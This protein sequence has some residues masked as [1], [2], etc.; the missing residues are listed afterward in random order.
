MSRTSI[1]KVHRTLEEATVRMAAIAGIAAGVVDVA[2]VVVDEAEVAVGATAVVAADVT[3]VAMVAAEAGTKNLLPR[4]FT[5]SH[6]STV[7]ENEMR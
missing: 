5:D 1:A 3:A 2:A 6:R 7:K 4:I